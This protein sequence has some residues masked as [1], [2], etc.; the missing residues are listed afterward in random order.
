MPSSSSSSSSPSNFG[1]ARHARL[2]ATLIQDP[3]A[4]ATS[5][6]SSWKQQRTSNE[7]DTLLFLR[8]R[9]DSVPSSHR[10]KVSTLLAQQIECEIISGGQ[11]KVLLRTTRNYI[12]KHRKHESN[13][14][15]LSTSWPSGRWCP[16]EYWKPDPGMNLVE[17]MKS[18]TKKAIATGMPLESLWEEGGMLRDA[19]EVAPVRAGMRRLI[20][21]QAIG[22]V[23]TI[24]LTWGVNDGGNDDSGNEEGRNEDNFVVQVDME[25]SEAHGQDH[26]LGQTKG[27]LGNNAEREEQAQSDLQ[28][29]GDG[30]GDDEPMASDSNGEGDTQLED[31]SHLSFADGRDQEDLETPE[32]GRRAPIG[33][34]EDFDDSLR[35]AER[36]SSPLARVNSSTNS[37]RLF[38]TISEWSDRS[39]TW[40]SRKR[41]LSSI[42]ATQK[43]AKIGVLPP[44]HVS[45]EASKDGS[46][47]TYAAEMHEAIQEPLKRIQDQQQDFSEDL[48]QMRE[49]LILA[50]SDA[51]DAA[52]N[53]EKAK[54]H[55]GEM[56][57][58]RQTAQCYLEDCEKY[59]QA[60][61]SV[62][63][64]EHQLIRDIVHSHVQESRQKLD[65]AKR[66]ERE[67]QEVVVR[68]ETASEAAADTARRQELA[69]KWVV[70]EQQKLK[71]DL[72]IFVRRLCSDLGL[73]VVG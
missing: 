63:S 10:L 52:Q 59:E 8:N 44:E 42:I 19:V 66:E 56:E 67:A 4:T 21:S 17:D 31:D 70:Q 3:A 60:G 6:L 41:A 9:L 69:Q 49:T 26:P 71:D 54:Q 62:I 1:H 47:L 20:C 40:T 18:I 65:E 35:A 14:K 13:L 58:R 30:I 43:K 37:P 39:P 23:K 73:A 46:G 12:R 38:G 55:R 16:P 22:K 32:I 36:D 57:G 7:K 28:D 24:A 11:F 45:P 61:N 50:H 5:L 68:A 25:D 34:P 33:R 72:K 51:S 64:E 53:L 48:E 29:Q 2:D 27:A 15:F